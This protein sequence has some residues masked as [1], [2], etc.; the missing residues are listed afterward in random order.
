MHYLEHFITF[1]KST[2]NVGQWAKDFHSHLLLHRCHIKKSLPPQT[3]QENKVTSR[4][5]KRSLYLSF[6]V[7][8]IGEEAGTIRFTAFRFPDHGPATRS[9]N[10][11]LFSQ[12][13]CKSYV[14]FHTEQKTLGYITNLTC[15]YQSIRSG[16]PKLTLTLLPQMGRG[17]F[18]QQI[19]M[20]IS[21]HYHKIL[22]YTHI[23]LWPVSHK[24][25][26]FVG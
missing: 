17:G 5:L 16:N 10:Y 14:N 20:S 6:H 21:S 7:Y 9:P 13:N 19:R 22:D 15:I 11:Q 1:T 4:I 8:F 25:F 2:T 23:K 18:V 12:E 3:E 24:A 26:T